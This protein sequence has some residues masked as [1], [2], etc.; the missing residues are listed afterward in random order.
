MIK[1]ITQGIFFDTVYKEI[2]MN[3]G[4]S[5]EKFKDFVETFIKEAENSP[6][7]P[8]WVVFEDL[9]HSN[10]QIYVSEM[11]TNRRISLQG[12]TSKNI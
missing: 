3:S 11:M 10:L 6:K 7:E 8:Y 4:L 12:G 1:F 9:N 5:I 2:K